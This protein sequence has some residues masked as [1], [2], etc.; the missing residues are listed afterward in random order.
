MLGPI[1]W[2]SSTARGHRLRATIGL[3]MAKKPSPPS[4]PFGALAALR[5]RLPPG[6]PPAG[7]S[8]STPPAVNERTV[9]RPSGEPGA[10]VRSG[11]ARAVVRYQRKGRGGKEVTLVDKL[12]LA[13]A[14]LESWCRDL[15]RALGC[16]G[17]IEGDV[18]VL[19]GDQRERLPRLLEGRGVRRVTVS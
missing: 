3:S 17:A 19:A 6:N 13:P 11:P 10:D 1:A 7:D 9:V 18:I 12:E 5:D 8:P 15:K 2:W 16:G 4:G 14:D